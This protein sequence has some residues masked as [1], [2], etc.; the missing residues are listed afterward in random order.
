VSS[1]QL[2]FRKTQELTEGAVYLQPTTFFRH[3]RHANR[4]IIERAPES[5]FTSFEQF[6]M[7]FGFPGL[8]YR[9]LDVP[10][11]RFV[12]NINDC[13][14]RRQQEYRVN[15]DSLKLSFRDARNRSSGKITDRSPKVRG[16]PGRQDGLIR[17]EGGIRRYETRLRDILNEKHD[18]DSA[19]V[20]QR[21][22][23]TIESCDIAEKRSEHPYRDKRGECHL[24]G[25]EQPHPRLPAYI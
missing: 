23:G 5:L 20:D 4:G 18:A 10:K 13:N 9:R 21:K 22:P 19:K 8:S 7:P 15:R 17:F 3:Q 14:D 2:T 11:I 16:P 25:I 12:S 24:R 6:R 1:E